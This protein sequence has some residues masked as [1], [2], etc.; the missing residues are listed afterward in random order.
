MTTGSHARTWGEHATNLAA[1]EQRGSET[2]ALGIVQ[3][4]HVGLQVRVGAGGC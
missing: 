2:G 4:I 3:P 1:V